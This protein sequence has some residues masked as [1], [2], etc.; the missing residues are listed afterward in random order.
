M[1]D[2]ITNGF[3][4]HII[5]IINLLYVDIE[6]YSILC[7]HAGYEHEVDNLIGFSLNKWYENHE[8]LI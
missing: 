4:K 6:V 1:K 5:T 3:K 7:K 8:G 2:I